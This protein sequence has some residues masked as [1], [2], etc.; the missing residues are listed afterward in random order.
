[1]SDP[2]SNA[3]AA[4]A[5]LRMVTL[6]VVLILSLI[7]LIPISKIL[8]RAGWSGWLSLLFFIPLANLI[9]LWVFAFGR[10]PKVP[11]K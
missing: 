10:W 3:M 7:T 11:D 4:E 9:F 5:N 2:V 1:M 6:F 8:R